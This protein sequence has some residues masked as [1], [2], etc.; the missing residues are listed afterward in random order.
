MRGKQDS[1][2]CPAEKAYALVDGG[3]S[4]VLMPIAK[5]SGAEREQATSMNVNLE[6]VAQ[7]V[8]VSRDEVHASDKVAKLIPLGSADKLG[9][10]RVDKLGFIGLELSGR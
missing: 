4:P 2:I 1:P 6:V 7:D 9:L 5:L 10:C 3:A 8:M